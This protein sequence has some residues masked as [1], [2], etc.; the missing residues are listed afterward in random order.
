MT[1]EQKRHMLVVALADQA[2]T[3]W[4][5][6]LEELESLHADYPENTRSELLVKGCLSLVIGRLRM[7]RHETAIAEA[8]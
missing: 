4:G 1:E 7:L 5:N 6:R 8:P 3:T 2:W